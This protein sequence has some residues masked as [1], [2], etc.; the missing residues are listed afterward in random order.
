MFRG[1]PTD[2]VSCHRGDFERTT[3]P[4]HTGAKFS[5]TCTN[6]HTEVT[7]RGATFDHNTTTFPLTGAHQAASCQ[8]CHAD[9]VFAGK[10]TTCIGCHQT[11]FQ[12]AAKPPHRGF[13]TDCASCH[14]TATWSGAQF[15]HNRTA[16]PLTG[17]HRAVQ[18]EQCHRDGVYKG[19]PLAC[20]GCHQPDYNATKNPAHQA[21][22]FPTTCTT[23]HTTTTW[24][25]AQFSHNTTAFP[26][27]GGH[28]AGACSSCH[29]D[30]VYKGKPTACVA[31]HQ[32][33][34]NGTK[35][36]A[37]QAAGFPT[38]C[39]T[40]H[41]VATW[42]GA[43]F[44]HNTTAFPLTGA[45][46]AATCA[47]CHADGVYKGKP[48]A[49]VA[50]HLTNFNGTTTPNHKTA[51]FPTTC[52][53]CHTTTTWT[54]ATFDHNT[55]A[56]PLT[57]AHRAA[58]CA[59]CHADGV[60]KGK[61][62][63]CVACH[64]TNFNGTT[65]PNHKAAG[66]PTTC[67]TCHTTTTWSG[68]TFDH[69]TTAFPLTGAH[70]ATPC[71]GC[72][73]EGVYQGKPTTCVAC[74][75]TNYNTTANPNHKTAGF[76]TSCTTCHTTTQWLGATFNHDGPYFPIYSGT[77]KGRWSSCADCH[78]NPANY[79]VFTCLSCH[80]HSDRAKTDGNHAGRSGYSYTSTACY[81]CHP[82]GTT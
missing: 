42:T 40:C 54:G 79:A 44:D 59:S 56:F 25:G 68:A 18:C 81:S 64:L 72:H 10:A 14:T 46:R 53:T 31:C 37:H 38:T 15:D 35:N 60:Y 33:D 49:C 78:T 27:T 30:G 36:P 9:G 63:A 69:N 76:P 65:T 50:C 58:T 13:P 70:K 24:T 23:C 19:K 39:T 61:P 77:H 8:N 11:N 26:L 2:C 32:P 3:N 20:V 7:W 51:G 73:A 74:H 41:T 55:T 80:P 43:T 12:Q 1:A 28:Q 34:Y 75:L 45:H 22:G 16:F 62:T 47:S 67:T 71:A 21:A 48:T 66:F 29:A 17:A 4:K 57:G 52:T 82:R 5:A 6:C